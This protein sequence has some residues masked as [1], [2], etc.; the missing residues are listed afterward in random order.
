MTVYKRSI[1]FRIIVFALTLTASLAIMN[2]CGK[3]ENDTHE[4]SVAAVKKMADKAVRMKNNKTMYDITGLMPNMP[5]MVLTDYGA[6]GNNTVM[7]LYVD[8]VEQ[9]GGI[10][11]FTVLELNVT[12]GSIKTIAENLKTEKSYVEDKNKQLYFVSLNPL[13][14]IDYHDATIYYT[15]QD[16]VYRAEVDIPQETAPALLDAVMTPKGIICINIKGTVYMVYQNV[17]PKETFTNTWRMWEPLSNYKVTSIE[18]C[19]DEYIIVGLTQMN[20]D[21]NI[22]LHAKLDLDKEYVEEFYST[23]KNEAEQ[24]YCVNNDYY[25]S[26]D[27]DSGSNELAITLRNGKQYKS[28]LKDGDL[29]VNVFKTNAKS[30]SMSDFAYNAESLYFKSSTLSTNSKTEKG[31]FYLWD[32][33]DQLP[34]DAPESEHTECRFIY[35]TDRDVQELEKIIED[36][37]GIIINTGDE[38]THDV[39]PYEVEVENDNMLKYE[40]LKKLDEVLSTYPKGF[41]KQLTG[42]GGIMKINLVRS[43]RN[44][45]DEGVPDAAGLTSR[46]TLTLHFAIGSTDKR[47]IYHEI[48]HLIYSYFEDSGVIFDFLNEFQEANPSDFTYSFSY[49]ES[50]I[51]EKYTQLD[52]DSY[53]NNDNIYFINSYSKTYQ[54]EDVAELMAYLLGDDTTPEYYSSKHLQEKCKIFF[55]Y[56]RNNFDVS[57]WKEKTIWEARLANAAK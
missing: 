51:S 8:S 48:T 38:V 25:I 7:L 27:N 9:K 42:N 45:S 30:I 40:M 24:I 5:D 35:A 26:N 46:D 33:S 43:L 18:Q 23:P 22:D 17:E 32:I 16:K 57:D 14:I 19:L 52:P 20:G 54:T 11:S 4:T 12:D 29:F 21:P 44:N 34:V 56:I 50:E 2:G 53:E 28:E 49:N 39:E 15:E 55:K 3:P 6:S 31:S 10:Y 13:V 1:F 37:Y 41:F 36:K 47:T